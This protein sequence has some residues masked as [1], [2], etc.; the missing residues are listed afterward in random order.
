LETYVTA[1]AG[2][3]WVRAGSGLGGGAAAVQVVVV[4]PHRGAGKGAD[5]RLG[6][7]PAIVPEEGLLAVVDTR[8]LEGRARSTLIAADDLDMGARNVH[9]SVCVRL[10]RSGLLNANKIL[11]SW[12]LGRHPEREL[13]LLPCKPSTIGSRSNTMA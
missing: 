4:G 2:W 3:S 1:A 10:V 13:L 7:G 9:F 11:T 6:L 8:D 12:D 5:S